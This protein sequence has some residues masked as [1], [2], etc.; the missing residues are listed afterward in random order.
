M[1]NES[2]SAASIA[3]L[4]TSI[5][6][7][8]LSFIGVVLPLAFGLVALGLATWGLVLANRHSR[9]GRGL[10]TWALILALLACANALGRLTS[11]GLR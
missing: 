5:L 9:G 11:G 4:T 2:R 7:L 3:A 8:Y 6:A 10:A 1:N